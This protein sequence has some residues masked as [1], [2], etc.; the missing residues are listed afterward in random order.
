[1]K[2][3]LSS[4]A[5]T[6]AIAIAS[7]S[8]AHAQD[9]S[10]PVKAK[11]VTQSASYYVTPVEFADFAHAYRLTNGQV[12]KFTQ[13]G[14]LYFTQL[15]NGQRVRLFALSRDEFVTADGAK[16][17]FGEDGETVGVDNFEKLPMAAKLPANTSIMMARR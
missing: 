10:V 9:A 2:I 14:N 3:A 7:M 15:D 17:I 5:A 12:L 4:I 16:M 6:F 11:A 1:M 8:A 13:S